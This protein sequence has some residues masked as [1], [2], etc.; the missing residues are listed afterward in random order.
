MNGTVEVF[1]SH[2]PRLFGVAYRMLGSR[3]DAEDLVQDACLRRHQSA[4]ENIQSPAAFLLTVT[5]RLCLHRLRQLKQERAQCV[6]PWL[7]EPAASAPVGKY[8][9]DRN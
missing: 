2:R 6:G 1:E 5:T 4:T 7:P 8:R 3:T 9:A